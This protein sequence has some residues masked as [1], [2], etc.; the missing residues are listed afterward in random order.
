MISG[1]KHSPLWLSLAGPLGKSEGP[2]LLHFFWVEDLIFSVV[3]LVDLK[4]NTFAEHHFASSFCFS[5]RFFYL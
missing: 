5:L 3:L 1:A 4:S 2:T